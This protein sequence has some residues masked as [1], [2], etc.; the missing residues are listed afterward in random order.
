MRKGCDLV[1]VQS[2]PRI[3][4]EVRAIKVQQARPGALSLRRKEPAPGL[5]TVKEP[6]TERLRDLYVNRSLFAFFLSRRIS[7]I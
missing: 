1:T 6:V 4:C 3:Y 7:Y 5:V 2:A